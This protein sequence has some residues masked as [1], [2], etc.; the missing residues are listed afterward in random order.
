MPFDALDRDGDCTE[1]RFRQDHP[2]ASLANRGRC[3]AAIR[4]KRRWRSS[5]LTCHRCARQ[6]PLST[7]LPNKGISDCET[8]QM[9][10]YSIWLHC[11]GGFGRGI[12]GCHSGTDRRVLFRRH[13][14]DD[15][16]VQSQ[17]ARQLADPRPKRFPQHSGPTH[18]QGTWNSVAEVGTWWPSAWLA[19]DVVNG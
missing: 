4:E 15:R 13:H 10:D 8:N 19:A 6:C 1:P 2:S 17:L 5:A 18:L 3:P 12:S 11:P 14:P 7:R 16:P 9:R